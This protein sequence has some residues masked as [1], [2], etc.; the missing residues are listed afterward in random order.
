[1][2]GGTSGTASLGGAIVNQSLVG[3]GHLTLSVT[4][5]GQTMTQ[6]YVWS[7]F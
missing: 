5:N 6:T 3:T 2:S 1:M 7:S 4:V